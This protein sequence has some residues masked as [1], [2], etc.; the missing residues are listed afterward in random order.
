MAF[1]SKHALSNPGSSLTLDSHSAFLA[2]TA[3]VVTKGKDPKEDKDS[4]S[5]VDRKQKRTSVP[6]NGCFVCGKSGHIARDCS[7]RKSPD[8]AL[9]VSTLN[10]D[11]ESIE[12]IEYDID[13]RESAYLTAEETVLLSIDD[14]VFDNG[15]TVHLIKNCRLL[16]DIGIASR[17]IVVNGVQS[18]AVG[19]RVNQERKLGDIG[20]V[21]YSKNASANILSMSS[22]VDAGA[23]VEY[24][25][26]SNKF[27]MQP[28]GSETFTRRNIK[29]NE[30][31]LYVCN[32]GASQRNDKQSNPMS[33]VATVANNMVRYT[34]RE[35]MGARKA[36]ELLAKLG[37]PT[38]ENAIAILRDGSGFDVT[39]Y[40]F[41]VADAIWGPDIASRR[42]DNS[43]KVDGPRC[44]DRSANST[45]ATVTGD[46]H[47]VYRP[48]QHASRCVLSPRLTLDRTVSGKPSRAAEPVKKSMDVIIP[49]YGRATLLSQRYIAMGREQLAKLSHS[50]IC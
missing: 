48:G 6:S 31:K 22:L 27:T 17:P 44:H 37:Y 34:K 40:D 3:F 50:S 19:V 28:K 33:F 1:R 36:R 25:R 43:I 7:Q 32:I 12:D 20:T 45:A 13:A 15:S 9:M 46:R 14:V 47:H 49:H 23:N 24:D 18:D 39:P 35:V 42:K 29:G 26:Q 16:T 2:D 8:V 30:S 5:P 21:Y 11:E 38:F 41:K 4:K 10:A